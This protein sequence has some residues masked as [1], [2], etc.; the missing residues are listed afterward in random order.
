MGFESTTHWVS[1]YAPFPSMTRLDAYHTSSATLAP[2]SRF[3]P[4]MCLRLRL[5]P[6]VIR[7]LVIG[8]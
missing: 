6:R 5:T 1:S 2:P 4:L 7:Q 8:R 3:S